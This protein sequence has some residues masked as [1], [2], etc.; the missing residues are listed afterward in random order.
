ML[1]DHAR[2]SGAQ[3]IVAGGYGHSKVREWVIGGTTRD[4]FLDAPVPVLFSH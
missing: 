4:L 1:I 3:L 2:R